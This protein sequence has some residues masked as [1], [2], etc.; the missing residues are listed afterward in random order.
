M[1]HDTLSIVL[2][3]QKTQQ[4]SPQLDSWGVD[5]I[6]KQER[7]GDTDKDANQKKRDKYHIESLYSV[8]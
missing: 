8:L 3:T 6:T 2:N 7:K 4:I 5:G 1:D